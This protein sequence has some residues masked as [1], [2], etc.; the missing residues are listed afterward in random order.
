MNKV[1]L[2]NLREIDK[3]VYNMREDLL[4]IREKLEEKVL[5]QNKYI[6]DNDLA[7][8]EEETENLDTLEE[9]MNTAYEAADELLDLT[10]LIEEILNN[11]SF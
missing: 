10:N 11:N 7:N 3:E 1:D 8:N 5:D 9:A 2:S 6:N 4:R